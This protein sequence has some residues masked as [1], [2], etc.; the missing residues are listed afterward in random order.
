[1]KESNVRHKS[2]FSPCP[3]LKQSL[4]NQTPVRKMVSSH[5]VLSPPICPSPQIKSNNTTDPATAP[6]KLPA[7]FL[8]IAP[9]FGAAVL[10]VLGAGAVDDELEDAGAEEL[11]G[12]ATE[13]EVVEVVSVVEVVEVT[14]P[15]DVE[16]TLAIIGV[17]VSKDVVSAT[18]TFGTE[19]VDANPS[20]AAEAAPLAAEDAPVPALEAASEAEA[21]ALWTAAEA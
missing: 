21:S 17:G 2:S 4:E 1:M 7:T 15:S 8:P 16:V 3:L 13:L 10:L 11:E 6:S 12:A 18:I 9:D 19:A 20:V 5:Y 14:I